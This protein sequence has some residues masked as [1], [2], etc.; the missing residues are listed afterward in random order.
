[1][2]RRRKGE[3]PQMRLHR[4]SGRAYVAVGREQH[5]LGPWG[6]AESRRAYR[7]F[8]RRWEA[9]QKTPAKAACVDLFSL[10]WLRTFSPLFASVTRQFIDANSHLST[11]YHTFAKKI[12]TSSS[13]V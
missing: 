13:P 3:A 2:P 10:P 12:V 7:D 5:Y 4:P 6:S 8:I 9:E 1:M 11:F